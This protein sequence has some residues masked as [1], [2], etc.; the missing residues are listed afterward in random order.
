M[1]KNGLQSLE[2]II[3]VINAISFQNNEKCMIFI[4]NV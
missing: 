2:T 4:L 1:P 3:N